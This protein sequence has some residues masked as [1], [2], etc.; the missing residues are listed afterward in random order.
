MK[1]INTN[2]I[3]IRNINRQNFLELHGINPIRSNLYP[4]SKRLFELLEL[5]DISKAIGKKP[6]QY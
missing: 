6:F 3:R 5:Y 4:V 2:T 1:N